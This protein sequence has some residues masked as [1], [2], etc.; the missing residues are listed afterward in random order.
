M[1]DVLPEEKVHEL[2]AVKMKNEKA[3]FYCKS[4]RSYWMSSG[5]LPSERHLF[6]IGD[7][8]HSG[9]VKLF[10]FMLLH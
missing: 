7:T 4:K 9:V 2:V 3:N 10:Y 8:Q 5:G 6:V 1:V